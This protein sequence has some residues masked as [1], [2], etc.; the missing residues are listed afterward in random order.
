MRPGVVWFGESLPELEW[1]AAVDAV[2]AC[3]VF[4]AVGTSALVQP[5][6]SLIDVANRAHAATVRINPNPTEVDGAVGYALRR[7]AGQVLTQLVRE[8]WGV[9]S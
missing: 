7:A 2:K 5:A 3:E 6:A 9:R 4:L 1:L 8:V